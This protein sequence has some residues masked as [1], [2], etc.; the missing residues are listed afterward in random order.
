M[1]IK[2]GLTALP[3]DPYVFVIDSIIIFFYVDDI[4]IASHPSKRVAIAKLER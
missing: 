1:L 3:E 2:L 4:L